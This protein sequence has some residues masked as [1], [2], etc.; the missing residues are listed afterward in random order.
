MDEK[1]VTLHLTKPEV[2]AL[3]VALRISGVLLVS[4]RHSL[5]AVEEKFPA[6]PGVSAFI[7]RRSLT[8]QGRGLMEK[9]QAAGGGL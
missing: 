8:A 5:E 3:S 1:T 6:K 2:F 4:R 7:A 9:L